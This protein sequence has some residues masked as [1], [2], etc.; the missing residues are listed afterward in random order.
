M[1]TVFTPISSF[2]GGLAIG[3]GA[4]IL[5]LSLRR[6]LSATGILSGTVFAEDRGEFK[7]R[8]AMI[9]GMISKPILIF[10]F[11]GKMPEVHVS[12]RPFVIVLGG[13]VVGFGASLGSVFA[14]GHRG[15]GLS[16]L[17]LRSLLF[18]HF[19]QQ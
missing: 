4:A 1:E 14:S 3:L 7:W 18:P 15:C 11:T 13:I 8:L 10:I 17:C 2:G 6:I 9:I 19:W 16:R 12:F 5:I